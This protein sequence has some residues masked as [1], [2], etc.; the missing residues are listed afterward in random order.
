MVVPRFF[1]LPELLN[2]ANLLLGK[3][4]RFIHLTEG[5]S[6]VPGLDVSEKNQWQE[7]PTWYAWGNASPGAD[8]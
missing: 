3:A 7:Q 4:E 6:S 8:L 1:Q 2:W 5:D